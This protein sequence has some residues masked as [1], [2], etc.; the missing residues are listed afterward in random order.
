MMVAKTKMGMIRVSL[1]D[2]MVRCGV[3]MAWAEM[4]AMARGFH[5]LLRFFETFNNI[6]A[7][8]FKGNEF[9]S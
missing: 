1:S 4:M 3:V 5:R 9:P 8:I 7:L 2:V 6:C